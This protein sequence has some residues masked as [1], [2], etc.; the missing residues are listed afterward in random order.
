[1]MNWV[2]LFFI[3]ILAIAVLEGIHRG[4]LHSALSLG[5]LFLSVI[6]AYLLY[7]AVAIAF[8][9]NDTIFK[10]LLYYTEGAEKIASFE[11]S[12]LLVEQLSSSE[13]STIISTSSVSEPFSTLIRQNVE[14]RAFAADGLQTIGEY[15][16]MTMV[17]TVLNVMSFVLIYVLA[18]I[19]Y[20][21]V[22][23]AVNY[24]IRFPELRQY[25]RTA[26]AVFG[27]LR[28]VFTCFL[29]VMVVPVVFLFV[30]VDK[31]TDYFLNSS[32]A[33]FFLNNNFFLH[34]I[35]GFV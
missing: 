22:L 4:F 8:K 9:A 14:T 18:R 25:D 11:N 17:C 19:V 26:G 24:T 29:V 1:M 5:A 2:N 10:F 28:G 35:R 31:I 30:P 21:F 3:L 32:V 34:M 16:N 7:P 23:G 6:T 12:R 15:F 13:L 27:G 20:A 33:M